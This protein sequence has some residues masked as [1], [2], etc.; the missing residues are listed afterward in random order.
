M[1]IFCNT[2]TD[3]YI[4]SNSEQKLGFPPGVAEKLVLNS[5]YK[6][7]NAS[8]VLEET[9][10]STVSNNISESNKST[11]TQNDNSRLS[12]PVAQEIEINSS[13]ELD[14][15]N[16]FAAQSRKTDHTSDSYNGAVRENYIWTQTLDDLD[17]LIKIPEHIKTPKQTRVNIS[18]DEIKID[19]KPLA[20]TENSEWDN[21]FDGRLCF[22]VR[23]DESV[24]SIVSGKHISVRLQQ[25]RQLLRNIIQYFSNL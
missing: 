25:I 14:T 3:F 16:A 2:S 4:E 6:W 21:I 9:K 24:W 18:S 8:P 19:V 22:K 17:V 20:S 13:S 10:P 7:K 15:T 11:V 23:R 5:M 12:P 1:M